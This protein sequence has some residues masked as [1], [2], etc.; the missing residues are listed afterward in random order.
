[1]TGPPDPVR[2]SLWQSLQWC[3][4]DDDGTQE[5]EAALTTLDRLDR[6]PQPELDAWRAALDG[7]LP[8]DASGTREAAER[9]LAALLD[10]VGPVRRDAGEEDR[11]AALAFS[12][13]LRALS[14]TGVLDEAASSRWWRDLQARQTPW[15]EPEELDDLAEAARTGSLIAIAVPPETPEEADEDADWEREA[16]LLLR[17]GEVVETRGAEAVRRVDG[18]AIVAVT[19]RTESVEVLFHAVGGASAGSGVQQRMEA[20]HQLVDGLH[21]PALSDE[22]GGTYAPASKTPIDAHGAGGM[23]D[24]DRPQVVTGRWRFLPAPA[25]DAGTL[26][27]RLRG[28][29]WRFPPSM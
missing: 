17:R 5:F 9:H 11:A 8:P 26:V 20:F 28:V 21:A 13:A 14:R 19:L 15:L 25:P 23:P 4:Q 22:A 7:E 12:G 16:E 18:V 10:G 2:W 6:L 27:V 1:V 3:A 29:E 24:Q